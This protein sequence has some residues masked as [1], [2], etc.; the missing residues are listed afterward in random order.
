MKIYSAA[1]VFVNLSVEETFGM[2][3]AEALACGTPVVAYD[4][5]AVPEVVDKQSGVIV[6]A[7]N[8]QE[9]VSGIKKAQ[10]ISSENARKRAEMFDKKIEIE[11]FMSIYQLLMEK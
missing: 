9:L 8:I 5:T 7:G 11:R 3:T 6:H 10:S 1:D 4:K 2:V